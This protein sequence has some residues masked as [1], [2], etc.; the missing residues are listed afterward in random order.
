M[1]ATKLNAY[2][3]KRHT[4]FIAKNNV[5]LI[6]RLEQPIAFTSRGLVVP[7]PSA[8]IFGNSMSSRRPNGWRY[9]C[10]LSG[11]SMKKMG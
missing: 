4:T 6:G 3:V 8:Q 7:W 9:S 5:G 11:Y 2:K 10:L 1:H